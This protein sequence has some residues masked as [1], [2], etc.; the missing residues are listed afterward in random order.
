[1][2]Q[3]I[4]KIYLIV[5]AYGGGART[6]EC[7]ESLF[8][9]D[10]P[11]F[12]ILLVDNKSRDDSLDRIFS[13]ARGDAPVHCI[14]D[15]HAIVSRVLPPVKKP[16]SV[17]FFNHSRIDG[18]DQFRE[19]KS[20][21]DQCYDHQL[22]I[23]RSEKNMGYAYGANIG[24]TFAKDRDDID[25]CWILNNDVVVDKAALAC[26]VKKADIARSGDYRIGCW[27]AKMLF[28]DNS[29]IIQS[30]GCRFNRWCAIG[31]LIGAY[32]KDNGH[33]DK[34]KI[35]IDYLNGAS[36]F[37]DM[38]MVSDIGLM[39]EE[40]FLYYEEVDWAIRAKKKGWLWDIC[41][42]AKV[43]HKEGG[44]LGTSQ[45]GSLRSIM[46]DYYG[47]RNRLIFTRKF[48]PYACVTVYLSFFIVFLNRIV[49]GQFG[50][51]KLAWRAM[52]GDL[53]PHFVNEYE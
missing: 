27:G 13:W 38:R 35:K 34:K 26:L 11:S 10:Y 6:I 51:L 42:D 50:R 12:K 8:K 53:P 46:A 49:R 43:F 16:V 24:M 3:N 31:F 45:K 2:E 32:S 7:L 23:I 41:L 15:Q 18:I 33:Y 21:D 28:Y 47:L 20:N 48:Y 25:F 19:E 37:V 29:D 44:A 5:I 36:L 30:V 52:L 14:S 17:S 4:K 39:N 22:M 9:I 40:Y 1:M